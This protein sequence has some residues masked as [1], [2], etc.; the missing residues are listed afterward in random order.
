LVCQKGRKNKTKQS[1]LNSK[2]VPAGVRIPIP[3]CDRPERYS[4][5]SENMV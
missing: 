4:G 2:A 3:H 5:T 1:Y